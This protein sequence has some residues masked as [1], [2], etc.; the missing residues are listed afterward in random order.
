MERGKETRPSPAVLGALARA[1][2]L[3]DAEHQHLRELAAPAAATPRTPAAAQQDRA[4][5]T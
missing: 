4:P 5:R 3:D 1:L 2:H